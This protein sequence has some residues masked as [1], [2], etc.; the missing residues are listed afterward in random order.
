MSRLSCNV[1]ARS[2]RREGVASF[3]LL[4]LVASGCRTAPEPL[5]L[6]PAEIEIE[7]FA[8]TMLSG[9]RASDKSD[10]DLAGALLVHADVTFLERFPTDDG[11][12]PLVDRATCLAETLGG[13]AFAS[14]SELL[15]PTRIV[16]PEAADAFLARVASDDLGRTRVLAS[17]DGV[18][19]P[20]VTA[21]V[22]AS[23]AD[24]S[25]ADA[26]LRELDW[27][28][29]WPREVNAPRIVL[30]ARG[31]ARPAAG[32][33]E[34]VDLLPIA[35]Q[36]YA[37][38]PDALR[39]GDRTRLFL[40]PC[41][42]LSAHGGA[43]LVRIE[44]SAAPVD[45]ASRARVFASAREQIAAASASRWLR[46]RASGDAELSGQERERALS[47]LVRSSDRRASLLFL[48][49]SSGADFAADL[50]LTVDDA[51]LADVVTALEP[52]SNA[53]R[54]LAAQGASLGFLI[55][56]AAYAR[57]AAPGSESQ[58][59]L[60]LQGLLARHAGVAAR[61]PGLLEELLATSRDL[62]GLRASILDE[63]KLALGDSD[64]VQRVRAY[65]WL[66]ARELAPPG[67]DPLGP[68]HERRAALQR[69]DEAATAAAEASAKDAGAPR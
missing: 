33:D 47:A 54:T 6:A 29:E 26:A 50:A 12:P 57:A 10:V 4:A 19:A 17:L 22:R 69:A 27:A 20:G 61:A 41:P 9:P 53:V 34:G 16:P 52:G 32:R 63:N 36:E 14:T 40:A 68:A 2:L 42:F 66:A 23:A 31:A 11:F 38:M 25:A 5:E 67:F 48:A 56:K 3:G 37:V 13:E 58:P 51:T 15:A 43:M 8:G 7:H 55:E 1:L 46:S 49:Q 44:I 39:A 24:R 59:S 45:D 35:R 64:P 65:D 28:C 21:L 60:A 62:A 18:V 30:A